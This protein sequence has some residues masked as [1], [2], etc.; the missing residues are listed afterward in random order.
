MKRPQQKRD[1]R[2]TR[3]DAPRRGPPAERSYGRGGDD[4]YGAPRPRSEGFD[5]GERPPRRTFRR[6]DQGDSGAPSWGR[7][8]PPRFGQGQGQD[9]SR[10]RD[11]GYGAS[12]E[13][14]Y[15]S[16][17]AE[18]APVRP[19]A[20]EP[21]LSAPPAPRTWPVPGH[22]LKD[23]LKAANRALAELLEGFGTQVGGSYDIPEIEV[24]VSFD[25]QGRFMG[26]G[27]GG[28]VTFKLTLAPLDAE[29]I[30]TH[31]NDDDLEEEEMEDV[32]PAAPSAELKLAKKAAPVEAAEVIEVIE[33]EE[34]PSDAA[35]ATPSKMD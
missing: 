17:S 6:D 18:S 34:A 20:A 13:P 26:F 10:D 12:R 4:N 31:A 28:C 24:E 33:S 1:F 22:R 11:E 8:A 30:L 21:A 9:R 3:N 16:R 29:D 2:D 19:A 23:G 32:K 15:P 14:R 25:Q 5:G 7:S 27:R 35:E